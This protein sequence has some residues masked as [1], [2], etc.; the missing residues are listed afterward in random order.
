M[1]LSISFLVPTATVHAS[2]SKEQED[3]IRHEVLSDSILL[4]V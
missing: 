3:G 1:D 2:S 4:P